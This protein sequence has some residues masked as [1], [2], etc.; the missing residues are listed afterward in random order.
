M[1]EECQKPQPP[2]LLK[3][4]LQYTSNL[5]CNT[6]PVC[7][8]VLSVAL[9]S[10]R[11]GRYFNT[12]PICIA[13]RL[14]LVSQYASHLCRSAL[15]NPG[16]CSHRDVPHYG[17]IQICIRNQKLRK[18]RVSIK[19]LSAKFGFTSPPPPPKKAQNEEKLYKSVEILK[20]DT[21]SGGGET[22]FYGQN[23][24]MDIS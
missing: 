7:I 6:L 5:Y 13:V 22:R 17:Y 11:K 20:I 19:F 8:A 14:P 2:L 12:P 9:S 3:K 24:F 4:V 23:D 10:Q 21:I 1:S 18:V 15:E 16:G